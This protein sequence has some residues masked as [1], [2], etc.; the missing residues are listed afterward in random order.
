MNINCDC[1]YEWTDIHERVRFCHTGKICPNANDRPTPAAEEDRL[2]GEE[3]PREVKPK[4]P[5]V[6]KDE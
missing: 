6:K 2:N 5:K 4:K 3:L 1:G